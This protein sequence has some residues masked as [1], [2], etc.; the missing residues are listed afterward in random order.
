MIIMNEKIKEFIGLIVQ[1]V[2]NVVYDEIQYNFGFGV[3]KSR[4]EEIT[5]GIAKQYFIEK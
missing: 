1:D 2:L 3:A 5:D 4:I